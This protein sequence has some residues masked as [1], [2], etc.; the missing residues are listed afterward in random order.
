MV[1]HS[2]L[3]TTS[4]QK[5]RNKD[6]FQVSKETYITRLSGWLGMMHSESFFYRPLKYFQFTDTPTLFCIMLMHI[7]TLTIVRLKIFA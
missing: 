1:H 7:F 5:W 6:N 4:N 2:P 3:S